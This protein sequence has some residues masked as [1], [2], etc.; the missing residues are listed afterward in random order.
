M[1]WKA[2]PRT[3]ATLAN[4]HTGKK[5]NCLVPRRLSG[6]LKKLERAVMQNGKRNPCPSNIDVLGRSGER[7]IQKRSPWTPASGPEWVKL[8]VDAGLDDP[9]PSHNKLDWVSLHVVVVVFFCRLDQRPFFCSSV[10][11]AGKS[12]LAA[13]T[14]TR[15]ALSLDL[16]G[17][18]VVYS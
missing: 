5:E 18:Y 12:Y 3:T 6:S 1:H 17:T 2:D 8:D 11:E 4:L 16:D 15:N 14:A 13:L 9:T 10:E 7:P